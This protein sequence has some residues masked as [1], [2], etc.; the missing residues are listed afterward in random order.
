MG[1]GGR[2]GWGKDGV[3]KKEEGLGGRGWG[4]GKKVLWMEMG[5]KL[6]GEEG[7]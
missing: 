7:F 5:G 3:G 1:E 2:M 6:E 4:E